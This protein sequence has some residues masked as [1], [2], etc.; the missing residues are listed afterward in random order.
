M[1]LKMKVTNGNFHQGQIVSN[2]AGFRC[3]AIALYAL[4]TIFSI[5]PNLDTVTPELIDYIVLNGHQMYHQIITESN[6]QMPRYLGH[7][8]LPQFV[9]LNNDNIEIYTYQNI[10][11]GTVGMPSNYLYNTVDIDEAFCMAFS[12]SNYYVGTFGSNTIAIFSYG[13]IPTMVCI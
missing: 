3:T 6:N 10:L 11:F 2:M 12:I 8:E 13:R 4:L 5:H 7:W 1:N 9:N